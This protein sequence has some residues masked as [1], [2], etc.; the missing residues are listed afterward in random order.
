METYRLNHSGKELDTALDIFMNGHRTEELDVTENGKYSPRKGIHSFSEVNVNVQPSLKELVT[1]KPGVYTPENGVYGYSKV[2]V[3]NIFDYVSS[4]DSTFC[5]AES[6]DDAHKDIVVRFGKHT[7]TPPKSFYMAF[8]Y[9]DFRSVTII[10]EGVNA[11]SGISGD[12][13]FRSCKAERIDISGMTHIPIQTFSYFFAY[14]TNL[15]EIVG[16]IDFSFASGS[17]ALQ[18]TFINAPSLEEVRFKPES[19]R[20]SVS[21]TQS[22]LLSDDSI[23]SIIEGLADVTG[24]SQLTVSFPSSIV[25]KLTQEQLD[26]IS[27]KNWVTG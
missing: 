12:T 9:S 1:I 24:N 15:K 3:E 22:Y 4:L 18:S 16:E 17:K 2:E 26:I 11:S 23:N 19:L 20:F 10:H 25:K 8:A 14:T 7:T 27:S 6:I 21:F 13:M 5:N